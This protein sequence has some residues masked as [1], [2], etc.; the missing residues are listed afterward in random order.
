MSEQYG[1]RLA[2]V[3]VALVFIAGGV[4]FTGSAPVGAS[5]DHDEV[6]TLR[7]RGD[8]MPLTE[9]LRHPSLAGHRVIE[10]DLEREHGRLVYELELLDSTGRVYKREFDAV[11]GQPLGDAKED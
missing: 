4:L 1:F 5:D 10:A 9:V 3:F 6:R 11:G 8:V 2:W 7:E